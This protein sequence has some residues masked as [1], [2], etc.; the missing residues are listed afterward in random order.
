MT[1]DKKLSL[2]TNGCCYLCNKPIYEDF[3]RD[4]LFPKSLGGSDNKS[5][6]QPSHFYCNVRKG[7]KPFIFSPEFY[8]I[9][10]IKQKTRVHYMNLPHRIVDSSYEI[11]R[12]VL[13][14]DDNTSLSI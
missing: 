8:Q 4:H 12:G 1:N 6:I 5:N 2:I 10:K 7:D 13:Q 9:K 11:S 3:T 14:K